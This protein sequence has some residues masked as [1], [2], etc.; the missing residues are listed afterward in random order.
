MRLTPDRL[1]VKRARKRAYRIYFSGAKAAYE[2]GWQLVLLHL[3]QTAKLA[4][5]NPYLLTYFA[6]AKQYQKTY[7]HEAERRMN[8]AML[9]EAEDM[10]VKAGPA[11]GSLA[12]PLVLGQIQDI[13]QTRF[14]K[15]A[16]EAADAIAAGE[17]E[18]FK[19]STNWEYYT[20]PN[21]DTLFARYKDAFE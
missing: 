5:A 17:Q 10:L 18:W 4:A 11:A 2:L 12:D 20:P 16:Q 1:P 21:G 15:T 3:P 7:D 14:H 13:M 9:D 19:H 8:Q 6:T